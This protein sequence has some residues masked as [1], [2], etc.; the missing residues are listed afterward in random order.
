[1]E[2]L[3]HVRSAM[4]VIAFITFLGIVFWAWSGRRK[5]AFAEAAQLPFLKD[6]DLPSSATIAERSGQ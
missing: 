6:E 2:L 5:K 1:M 4:T 3:N